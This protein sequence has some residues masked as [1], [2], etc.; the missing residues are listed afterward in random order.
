MR[1][2]RLALG[3]G[4]WH[5]SVGVAGEMTIGQ[6]REQIAQIG[7]GLDAVHL[8]GADQAGEAGPVAAASS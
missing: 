5:Q 7:I 6:L 3:I 4:P 2:H 1:D 8:A